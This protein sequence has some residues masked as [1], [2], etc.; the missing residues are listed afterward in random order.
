M[1]TKTKT[2]ANP[3]ALERIE[4]ARRGL[5]ERGLRCLS[6]GAFGLPS[7]TDIEAWAKGRI[8]LY[9]LYDT[10]TGGWDLLTQL[11][12]TNNIAATWAAVEKL[13]E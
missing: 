3:E 9:L 6:G 12:T 8:V 4:A 1:A 13:F 5:I 10:S 2:K 7:Y 11:D